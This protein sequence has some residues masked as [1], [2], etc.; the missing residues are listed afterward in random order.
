VIIGLH[1]LC[2]IIAVVLFFI[3]AF[4]SYWSDAPKFHPMSAGLFFYALKDIFP[5]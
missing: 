3:A 4:W 5:V 2:L 1:N